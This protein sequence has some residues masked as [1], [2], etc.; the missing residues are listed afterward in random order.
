M[1]RKYE[2]M[3]ITDMQLQEEELTKLIELMTGII[4]DNGGEF[5]ENILIG[6]RYFTYPIK[7]KNIGN[8]SLLTFN[9]NNKVLSELQERLN[10]DDRLLRFVITKIE[11]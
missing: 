9:A 6:S 7:K 8:Y 1:L 3:Y 10:Y 4:K 5:V 2:C 11:H